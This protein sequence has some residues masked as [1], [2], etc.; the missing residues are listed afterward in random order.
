MNPQ[1]LMLVLI[2]LVVTGCKSATTSFDQV[3]T[4]EELWQH[5]P[6]RIRTLLSALDLNQPNLSAVQTSLQ[7]ADT[8]S[9]ARLLL[10]YY[11]E[12]DRNWVV[13]TIDHLPAD[14]SFELA[15][16]LGHDTVMTS[17]AKDRIP[18]TNMGGWQWDFTG[19]HQDDEFG[20]SL[21]GHKYLPVLLFAW[22]QSGDDSYAEVFDGIIKDW[23][24]NHPLPLDSDSIYLVLEG[25]DG[26][27]YRDL[28]EVEWRTLEAGNRLGASW[29]QLFYGFQQAIEFSPATRL[30][31]LSSIVEHANYLYQ[32][33]K[34]GHN[35]TTMEMNGLAL[36]GLGFPEFKSAD[37]WA[38]YAL[39][40]ME[41]EIN[42]QVYPDGVQ[43]E[44]STKTQW[45]A[46][47]RFESIATNFQKAGREISTEYLYRVEEMYNYL[48]YAMRPD[49]H[50]PLNNDS[51]REDLRP[52]VLKAAEKFNRPDWQWIATNGTEGSKPDSLPSLVFPWGGMSIM[53]NGW[54]DQA[55]W[56]FFDAGPF[57][58]GHQHADKLHLSISAFGKDLLVDG[59]RYTHMNYFSFDPTIWRG[60]FRSSFSHNVILVDEKGQKGG[61][62]MV[63]KPLKYGVDFVHRP[64]FDFSK[65]SFTD[66]YETH[67]GEIRHDR[68]VLYLHDRYW[69]VVDHFN[70]DQPRNLQVLW[71]YA[72]SCEVVIEGIE[73]ISVNPN[74]ANLR[75]TPIG[76]IAWQPELISG[77]EKPYIQGWYSADYG[78][79]QPNPTIAYSTSIKGP[80]TFAW[81]LIPAK[82]RVSKVE[83][84][85]EQ[86][87]GFLQVSINENGRLTTVRYPEGGIPVVTGL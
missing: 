36:A 55:H 86:G 5:H 23:T 21:N 42:R 18:R 70:T 7:S 22:K 64:N 46:L 26:L 56:S 75:I 4:I 83:T 50:Q 67:S 34:K 63:D 68:S 24:L 44:I 14:Q 3:T 74:E 72:P 58:T 8:L 62:T 35:W 54:D 20:Y 69:V 84:S 10:D 51:D 28:G 25:T 17:S 29:S 39:K 2:L 43:T 47:Y 41:E 27:D 31:M 87:N 82:G 57:G 11:R 16:L 77:Q 49:G 13:S 9:A 73:A 52:R 32:Y 48:A 81:L 85:L 66:G 15:R 59:G 65:G 60:Y 12:K 6:D 80:V 78:S 19:P 37:D 1:L 61:P 38:G 76:E 53:R 33:H 45:V 71:H 79:K 30:L 40:V